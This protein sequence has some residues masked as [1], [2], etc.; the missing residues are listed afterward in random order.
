M[1]AG[2][3]STLWQEMTERYDTAGGAETARLRLLPWTGGYDEEFGRLCRDPEAMRFI[4]GGMP[5][6]DE[7]IHTITQRSRALWDQHG[8]GPWAAIHKQTGRWV[9][10]IGLN[11]L[12]DWPGP[13][14]WEVGFELTPEHWGC[15]LAAEGAL[16]AID[17]GWGRT[18]LARIISATAAEHR[19][20]RRVMEKCG[21]T[22]QA[23]IAFRGARV[24]WYAIDRPVA[25]D[26]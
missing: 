26:R 19:A 12:P 4:S 3:G 9:G 16:A 21:L 6:A 5:L 8:Y 10:R 13:D 22:F 7:A 25:P 15:G 20:S 11:L 14:K 2:L 23:E 18:P 1:R 17:F 24:V